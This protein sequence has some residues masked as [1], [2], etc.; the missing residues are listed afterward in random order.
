MALNLAVEAARADENG[1]DFVVVADEGKMLAEEVKFIVNDMTNIVN[2]EQ[3]A[4]GEVAS[5]LGKTI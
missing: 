5:S 2:S 3:Q 4:S 1:K